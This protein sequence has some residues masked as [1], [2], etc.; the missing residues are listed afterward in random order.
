MFL[1]SKTEYTEFGDQMSHLFPHEIKEG[2]TYKT[3]TF[4]VTDDCCM[5]CTYCYQIQ[6][7]HN[8]M[9][10]ETAKKMVDQLLNDET[11]INTKNTAGLIVDFIGGEPLMEIDLIHQICDY[12]TDEMIR[13]NHPWLFRHRFSICS[14]GLLYFEENVQKFL[15]KYNNR[16]SFT[17]SIDGNKELHDM[18]RLDLNGQGT[19][20][21]AI[22]AVKYH[23]EHYYDSIETKMTLAPENIIYTKDA[24]IGLI[25]AGY[26]Q[27]LLN[28][29]FEEGWTKKHATELYFQLKNLADFLIENEGY[30]KYYISIFQTRIGGPMSPEDNQNWCGGVDNCMIS[31][32]YKGD[33]YPCIRY[34]ESSLGDDQEP[35]IIGNVNRGMFT[36]EKEKQW[37]KE[38]SGVTRKSQS[39][40]ECFNCPIA[41]GCAWCSAYNYQVFGTVNK[42]ATFI[43][44]MHKARVLAC[45]YYWNKACKKENINT[46]FKL[47]I[48]EEWAL[49]IIPKEEWEM[50]K[51]LQ[52]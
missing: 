26:T 1:T 49:E 40:E 10:F 32:D 45:S 21:R 9:P 18:C 27:I 6:K 42:R 35:I 25:D 17:I 41:K 11:Y 16:L 23:R 34:M 20:D 43:C 2:V 39:T 51:S 29:V 12:I 8:V 14:N 24:V 22:A 38:L 48:P 4:Q 7:N 46:R 3:F 13:L 15:R 31:I 37:E 52:Y 50:L 36:N 30:K 28:C 44:D 47:W 19:Y 33:I 5:A